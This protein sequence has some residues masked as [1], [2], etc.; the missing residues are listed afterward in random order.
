[1]KKRAA[2]MLASFIIALPA[3]AA[4]VALTNH[5]MVEQRVLASDGTVQVKRVPAM[6]AVPGDW[7]VYTLDYRNT[8]NQPLENIVLDNPLPANIA[9]RA[10]AEG[11]PAPDLS[12]DGHTFGPLA[13]LRV[14]T[15]N[16]LRPATAEDVTH[17]RW[18]VT[19]A[20]PAGGAGEVAFKAVLK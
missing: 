12:V 1:M 19:G 15:A 13:A 10:P 6:R 16:G 17:V 14:S 8:G 2:C 9:Y 18:R 20:L 4:P 11:S 5:V 7:L 3:V